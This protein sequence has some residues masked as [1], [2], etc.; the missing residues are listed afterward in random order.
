[1]PVVEV[2]KHGVWL[3]AKNVSCTWLASIV[4][5]STQLSLAL[6]GQI[7]KYLEFCLLIQ[8][9][10]DQY[11]HRILV[12]EDAKNSQESDNELFHAAADAGEKIYKK[13]DFAASKI[14]NFDTYLLKKVP[15]ADSTCI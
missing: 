14:S 3:L 8:M 11:I 13:G 9:Q 7:N 5:A 12:E 1:M 15:R 10:V 6:F 2:R 4:G